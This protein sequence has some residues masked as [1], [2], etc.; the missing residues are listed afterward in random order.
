[1]RWL[2]LALLLLHGLIHGL[3]V[4]D[5]F[6]LGEVRRLSQPVSKGLGVVW[7]LAGLAQ[8]GAAITLFAAPRWWWALALVAVAL[9]QAAIAT[10]WSDA[11]FGTVANALILV[12]A[13]YGCAAWG[14][15]SLRAAYDG[16]LAAR[17]GA[18][19]A[20]A[21]ITEAELEPLPAPV[22]G[23]LR[24]AGVVGQP[25]AQHFAIRWVGRIRGAADAPWMDFV[26]EQVNF[27][28]EPA[29]FFKMDA[30]RGGLP[31]DV[32]HVFEGGAASM[33]VRLLSLLPMVDAGGPE[34]TRS[35][36]VT[37]LNDM[38]LFAPTA[39]LSRG[40]TWEAIDDRRAR[41]H[42]TAGEHTV[43]AELVF[44]YTAADTGE[45]VYELVDFI[46]DDRSMASPTGDAFTR[47]RWSTP[48]DAHRPYGALRLP[49]RGEA[50]WHPDTGA[51]NYI[52][53]EV[54]EVT[55]NGP[56]RRRG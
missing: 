50:R 54:V 21:P 12:A 34:M 37:V 33:R 36:T 29:R 53:A 39:L 1:M 35:E 13:I 15:W 5:A 8:I 44:E 4:V 2:L 56:L 28:D 55:I 51:F 47:A 6:G 40:L 45:K 19:P 3:G 38:V 7:L 14:P 26:A 48:V 31:V 41:V 24:R 32:L 22:R 17:A 16:A 9:S 11:R 27:V 52:E 20:A 42:Y 25:R 30:R 10:A 43:S 49:S 18:S 23:Y 46:S